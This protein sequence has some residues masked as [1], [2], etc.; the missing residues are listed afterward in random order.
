MMSIFSA[1]YWIFTVWTRVVWADSSSNDSAVLI[2][3]GGEVLSAEQIGQEQTISTA[4]PISLDVVEMNI[5]EIIRI[6]QAHSGHNII[7]GDGI[8]GKVSIHIHEI[9]WDVAL[10]M[11]VHANNWKIVDLGDI[12]IIVPTNSQ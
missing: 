9:P 12:Y 3:L 2:R 6:F 5:A 10:L 1:F 8:E 4:K 11:V 7:L